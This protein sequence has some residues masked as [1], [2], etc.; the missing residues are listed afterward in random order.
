MRRAQGT[1]EEPFLLKQKTLGK[2]TIAQG[3]IEYLVVIGVIVI[4]GLVVVSLSTNF[5]DDAQS[6]FSTTK[7]ISSS[8]GVISI[9]E[10]IV[11]NDGNGLIGLTNNSNETLTITKLSV[12]EVEL[13]YPETILFQNTQKFFSL[14]EIE[15]NF[16]CNSSQEK[17]KI[18]EVIIFYKSTY[19][20]EKQAKTSIVVECVENVILSGTTTTIQ[21][22]SSTK[23]ITS[24]NFDD[25]HT[26]GNVNNTDFTVSLTVPFGTDVSA[27][28]P[29]ILIT[30]ES[31]VP[32]SGIAQDFSNPIIYTVTAANSSTQDYNV[33]VTILPP[34]THNITLNVKDFQTE[35]HLTGF[36][37]DCNVNDYDF[38]NQN[39]PKTIDMNLSSYSCIFSKA[40]YDSNTITIIV[41]DE[42]SLDIYLEPI[43]EYINLSDCGTLNI[44]NGNY[45]LNNDIGSGGTCLK[46][47]ANNI[48]VNGNDYTITGDINATNPMNPAWT[49]LSIK[50]TTIIG[51]I[52]ANGWDNASGAGFKGGDITMNNS[53]ATNI[54]VYGG[55]P[56]CTFMGCNGGFGGNVTLIDSNASII[57]SNGGQTPANQSC[58]DGGSIILINSNVTTV[59]SNTGATCTFYFRSGGNFSAT[60]SEISYVNMIGGEG[61]LTIYDSNIITINAHG[62]DYRWGNGSQMD[63]NNSLIN[64]IYAYGAI[65]TEY[66]QCHGGNGGN[67]NINNSEISIIEAYGGTGTG[68]AANGGNGGEINI[69][70]TGISI[71]KANGGNGIFWSGSGGN[72]GTITFDPCPTPKPDV[73]IDKG[74]GP[75][76][77]G[78]DGTINPSD[79]HN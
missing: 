78:L 73:N 59:N 72:G 61:E 27:L 17:T 32:A 35:E 74:Y 44:T 1:I 63:I 21:P 16:D 15:E 26:I 11:S 23:A 68:S 36:N 67:L 77:D 64:A 19:G 6:I 60:N 45:L 34:F 43:I 56:T 42:K 3:T 22:L 50:D 13:S 8:V 66:W 54:Y 37:I 71:I 2:K 70:N 29:N 53:K 33:T 25:P 14:D 47:D 4:I 38:I 55:N 58:G 65:T 7:K 39:S 41:D 62:R 49:N 9:N 12:D 52:F 20:L 5:F 75:S 57:D 76:G 51:N 48:Y 24:F 46:I 28:V 40:S 10:A 30:G 79:C 31:I 69:N 18:C